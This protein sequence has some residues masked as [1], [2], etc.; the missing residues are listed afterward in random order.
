MQPRHRPRRV[1]HR[2]PPGDGPGASPRLGIVGDPREPPA[3]LDGGRQLALLIE[4][5]ADRSNIGFGD[6]EHSKSMGTR[7]AAS[8]RDV[9]IAHLV[10]NRA[11][12]SD[13]GDFIAE[14]RSPGLQARQAEYGAWRDALHDNLHDTAAP[15]P[16][17]HPSPWRAT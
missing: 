11:P 14:P 16:A 9:P 7:A 13:Q 17:R 10:G 1:R 8:K 4:D 15:L 6:D 2:R 3:Q 12:T 5:S